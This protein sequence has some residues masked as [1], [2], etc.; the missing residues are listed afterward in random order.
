MKNGFQIVSVN[1]QNIS[2]HPQTV[3]YINPKHKSHHIK[4]DWLKQRFDEGYKIKLLYLE[5]EKRPSGF[6][7]YTNGENAWR[8]VSAENYLFIHCIW[9]SANKYKNK[10]IGSR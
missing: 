4:I 6:I 7:E 5:G 10:G 2:D 9:V 8:A 3:C 1:E